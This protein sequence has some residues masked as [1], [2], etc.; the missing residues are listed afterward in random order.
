MKCLKC[1]KDMQLRR[2]SIIDR[3]S[4]KLISERFIY[5]CSD[6]GI[7]DNPK[8]NLDYDKLL[9][10]RKIDILHESIEWGVL[11]EKDAFDILV[12]EE[13]YF[14]IISLLASRGKSIIS[15]QDLIEMKGVLK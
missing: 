9:E 8:P 13:N 11:I 6:C 7:L 1:Y 14:G 3:E 5:E 15:K 12:R 2:F 4:Y 10:K